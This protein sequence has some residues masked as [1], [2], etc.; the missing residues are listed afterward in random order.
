MRLRRAN[1]RTVV[2]AGLF[3]MP[4]YGFSRLL[5][6]LPILARRLARWTRRLL[7]E[8]SQMAVGPTVVVSDETSRAE[9]EEAMTNLVGTLH[10]MPEHWV[11]RREAMHA[12][13]DAYLDDRLAAK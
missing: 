11:D 13:L 4:T 12:K 5:A 6:D 3:V 8:V 10:R 1:L 9:L 2:V 7:S